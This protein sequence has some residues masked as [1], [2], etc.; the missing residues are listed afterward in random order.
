MDLG[1]GMEKVLQNRW[2]EPELSGLGLRISFG[3]RISNFGF[4]VNLLSSKAQADPE[5][6]TFAR[7]LWL[8]AR[9]H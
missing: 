8:L 3:S 9:L 5:G 6:G 2:L 1:G 4:Q 7:C